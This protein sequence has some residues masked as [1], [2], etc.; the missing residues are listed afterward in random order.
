MLRGWF[1]A[2]L[3]YLTIGRISLDG[4]RRHAGWLADTGS[5][6]VLLLVPAGML[7]FLAI[8]RMRGLVPWFQ[9]L[10]AGEV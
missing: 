9:V 4:D 5:P 3:A 6:D 10:R 8:R 2:H 7:C 1:G